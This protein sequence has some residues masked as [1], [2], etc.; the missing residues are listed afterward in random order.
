MNDD[1]SCCE[2][3][4]RA[5]SVSRRRFLGGVAAAST[6]AVA[7]SVF[8]D[9]VRQTAYAAT[10]GGNVMVVVSFRGGI[11]GL[12]VV[13]PHGD[14]AY[15]AARPRLA[16]PRESLIAQ[17]AMFGLHPALRPLQ[18]LWDSGELAAVNGVGMEMP[19]RSHFAA[20]E[21]VEDADP[22]SSVRSGWVNRMV[23]LDGDA[24]GVEAV[25]FGQS[26]APAMI[27]GPNPTVAA[28]SLGDVSLAG[29]T[30]GWAARRRSG[31]DTM[32]GG[33]NG[34]LATAARQAL[35]TVDTLSPLAQ[36]G[37]DATVEYPTSWPA[38]NFASALRDTAQLIKAD[39][40]AEVVS[41]DF[42]GWD[43]HDSYG[44]VGGGRMVTQLDGFAR[45]LDAFLR[46]L[47]PLR[48]RV[49]VLTISEFGRRVSENGNRGLDH[50]WGNM[51]LLAGAGVRGGQYHGSWPGL[52]EGRQ[53]EGDVRVTTDYRQ[54]LGEVVH[55]RF[56]GKDVSRVFPGLNYT[57]LGVLA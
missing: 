48:N 15:Y 38:T 19:N 28:T 40:G 54:V 47:G 20:M 45:S 29:S 27:S 14:P 36:R 32:W 55:K 56:R 9:A 50:G 34:P 4:Q 22:G 49:T 17:D 8:G 53:V 39:V 7:T 1:R 5:A 57:P 46:D 11:D 31:L 43:M 13:V 25:H 44:N 10:T 37:Y 16:V 6:T 18:W 12:G 33:S 24:S 52:G 2:E 3:Y 42:G 35:A 41:I 30:S 23:G 21:L 26:S 51:M